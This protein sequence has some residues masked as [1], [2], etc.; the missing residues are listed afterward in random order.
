MGLFD[1]IIYHGDNRVKYENVSF[2]TIHR[3]GD[4][5]KIKM[6]HEDGD[7]EFIRFNKGELLEIQYIPLTKLK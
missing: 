6:E 2:L 3:Y 5:I 4:N 7:E 1:V